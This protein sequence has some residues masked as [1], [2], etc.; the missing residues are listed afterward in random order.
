M[1]KPSAQERKEQ[2]LRIATDIFANFGYYKTT[3]AMIAK[4]ACVTQ[5]YLFHFYKT[6]E[7][8]YLAVLEKGVQTIHDAFELVQAPADQ[9]AHQ[10]GATFHELL[11]LK[12]NE[13]LL[14]MHSFVTTETNVRTFSREKHLYMFDMLLR[15]FVAAGI[16]NA[17][18]AVKQFIGEGLL[19]TVAEVLDAPTLC[20]K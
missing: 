2:I 9:L 10:L 16:P 12:R 4:E 15:K 11:R 19:L 20:P 13:M 18:V 6:K 14:T 8:L 3:T 1:T 7:E 5:P 17:P